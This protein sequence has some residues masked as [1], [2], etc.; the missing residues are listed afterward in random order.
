MDELARKTISTTT[1]LGLCCLIAALAYFTYY[2]RLK[3]LENAIKSNSEVWNK[4]LLDKYTRRYKIH[5]D[6][7][8][9]ATDT[10]KRAAVRANLDNE[11][12]LLMLIIIS[13]VCNFFV[14]LILSTIYYI[15]IMI[16]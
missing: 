2:Q 11:R 9:D 1:P 15:Y 7:L 8:D 16:K 12:K 13:F 3:R 4:K 5:I 6:D 10:S 14:C